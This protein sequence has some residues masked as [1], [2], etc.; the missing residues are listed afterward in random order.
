M[1]IRHDMKR[2]S[3]MSDL[4]RTVFIVEDGKILQTTIRD[5]DGYID[6]TTT[7][8]GIAPR[9]HVRGNELWTWG[10]FGAHPELVDVFSSEKEAVLA[11]ET[12]FVYDFVN[13]SYLEYKWF[14]DRES[15]VAFLA[16]VP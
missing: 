1:A 2:G 9:F 10:A 8:N 15:A 7:P 12:T 5:L 13:C 11:L 3:K 14:Y 6:M 4:D 16:D